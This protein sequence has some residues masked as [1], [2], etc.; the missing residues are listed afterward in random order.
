MARKKNFRYCNVTIFAVA[1]NSTRASFIVWSAAKK[2]WCTPPKAPPN[3][4]CMHDLPFP[5]PSASH[6]FPFKPCLTPP[7]GLLFCLLLPSTRHS[8]L[9]RRTPL[10]SHPASR[11][12]HHSAITSH[13]LREE[14][15]FGIGSKR[16]VFKIAGKQQQTQAKQ[17]IW[18]RGRRISGAVPS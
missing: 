9:V 15:H 4:N 11:V 8:P 7:A 18:E 17:Q 16:M 12:P 6:A 13:L 1:R 10:D 2:Y 5:L 14:A 3:T